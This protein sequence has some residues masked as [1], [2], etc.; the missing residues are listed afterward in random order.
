[1]NGHGYKN[2]SSSS[3]LSLHCFVIGHNLRLFLVVR[4]TGLA[5]ILSG[6]LSTPYKIPQVWLSYDNILG[7]P[8]GTILFAQYYVSEKTAANQRLKALRQYIQSLSSRM[9]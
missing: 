3:A 9:M 6:T 4:T 8:I 5:S 2:A 1:M 7:L